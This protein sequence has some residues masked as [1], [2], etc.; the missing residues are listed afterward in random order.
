MHTS[1]AAGAAREVKVECEDLGA[2]SG[3]RVQETDLLLQASHARVH[4]QLSC[5]PLR[6]LTGLP[7]AVMGVK[8][9]MT[10]SRCCRGCQ[11]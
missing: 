6:V 10:R 9:V 2:T 8:T 11:M 4:V 1:A 5:V 3:D 7:S